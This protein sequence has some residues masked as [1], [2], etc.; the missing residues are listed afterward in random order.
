MADNV[1]TVAAPAAVPAAVAKTPKKAKAAA[2][3]A[4]KPKKVAT[5]P[6]VNTMILAAIKAL[7]ERNGS[8]LQAIKKYLAANY[9]ADVAKLT[10]FIKRSL[11]TGVTNGKLVQTKGTGATG[12][13][14][15][16]AE[17]KKPVVEKKKK[18]VA[19]KKKAASAGDKKK[20]AVAKKPKAASDEGRW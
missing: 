15:L 16:S 9:T 12:S 6:P 14:K 4:K 5:H 2:S 17:A 18:V 19:P 13:F 20:K 3:G 1:A 8:S 7:K 10:P 11:K